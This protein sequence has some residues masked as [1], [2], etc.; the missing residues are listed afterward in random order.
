MLL[1]YHSAFILTD[2]GYIQT[3]FVRPPAKIIYFNDDLTETCVTAQYEL[4]QLHS[5]NDATVTFSSTAS[6]ERIKFCIAGHHNVLKKVAAHFEKIPIKNLTRRTRFLHAFGYLEKHL[7]IPVLDPTTVNEIFRLN[8][9]PKKDIPKD[10]HP[11]LSH[12]PDYE[13]TYRFVYPGILKN[14]FDEKL[15]ILHAFEQ[16]AKKRGKYFYL[17]LYTTADHLTFLEFCFS[18]N[19]PAATHIHLKN[20]RIQRYFRFPIDYKPEPRDADL[21][22]ARCNYVKTKTPS[23]KG[24]LL[25][26]KNCILNSF[27]I[28]E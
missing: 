15:K 6:R 20:D 10:F 21:I 14:T 8:S 27:L 18:L 23:T 3:R 9:Y 26:G 2:Y 19:I 7:A 5:S 28:C 25:P 4:F 1:R 24:L 11:Y 16:F 13:R 17:P 22:L 12:I